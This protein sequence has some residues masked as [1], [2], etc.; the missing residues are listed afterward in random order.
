MAV[1]TPFEARL[2]PV[3]EV[4]AHE[5]PVYVAGENALYFTTLPS[6]RPC[7]SR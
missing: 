7:G 5:G 2:V 1:V 6:P 3:V 4:D